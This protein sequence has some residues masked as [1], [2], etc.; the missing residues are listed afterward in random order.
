MIEVMDEAEN[1]I[2]GR[3]MKTK[4]FLLC[5]MRNPGCVADATRKN[6]P[7]IFVYVTHQKFK[8]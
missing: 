2:P 6:S 3:G 4:S 8:Y 7:N 1:I 5:Q